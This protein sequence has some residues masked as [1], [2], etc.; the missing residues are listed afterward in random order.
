MSQE[1]TWVTADQVVTQNKEVVALKGEPHA[2][3]HSTALEGS[4]ARPRQFYAYSSEG[5]RD[6]VALLGSLLCVGVSESQAFIQGNKR[7]AVAAMELFFQLNG[8]TLA[9]AP[10][11]LIANAVL[12]AAHPDKS[13]RISD[14]EF[15]ETIDPYVVPFSYMSI[16]LDVLGGMEEAFGKATLTYG[17]AGTVFP[18]ESRNANIMTLDNGAISLGGIINMRL[19]P[20]DDK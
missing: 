5:D 19:S 4:I 1:P 12:G 16:G 14:E 6:D 13:L 20:D 9:G 17:K 10:P 8:Y 3:V 15:A 11:L 7:T 18:L 2:I